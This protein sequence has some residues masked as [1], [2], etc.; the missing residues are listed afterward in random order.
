[1]I[2]TLTL[3]ANAMVLLIGVSGSGKTAFAGRHFRSTEVLSSDQLRAM[4]TDDPRQQSATEDAFGLLHAIL[5]MRLGR[6]R[7]T[8]IDATNVEDWARGVL[9]AIARRRRRPAAAIVLNLPLPTCLERNARR[10]DGRRP[11][12]AL[13]RQ[14]RW[15]QDS[16]P[17]LAQEG[18]VMVH[19]LS[20][21]EEVEFAR[22]ERT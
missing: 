22:V 14:H 13:R 18:F 20:T 4:I 15:L 8:V 11:P 21:V 2:R 6:G 5:E 19:V 16:L 17:A 12:A 10:A 1:M 7:L 9:L 3:P